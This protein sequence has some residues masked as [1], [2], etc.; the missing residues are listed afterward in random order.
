MI[1]KSPK[2]TDV[3]SQRSATLSQTEII[4]N[5]LQVLNTDDLNSIRLEDENGNGKAITFGVPIRF[6][7][8]DGKTQFIDTSMT[9]TGL[10]T[11]LFS[12]YEYRN[13]A[14]DTTFRFSKQAEKGV[15]IDEKFTYAVYNVENR[16]MPKGYVDQTF[17]GNGRM[18]YPEAFGENTYVE[19]INTNT[20]LKENIVLK[21]N[22][23]KNR[24]EF[25][26][27]SNNYL[28]IL[29][30]DKTVIKV[31][32]KDNPF[33]IKY[34]FAELY[35]YDSYQ[36]QEYDTI[37]NEPSQTP[38][39]VGSAAGVPKESDANDTGDVG[40]NENT[41]RHYTEDNYYELTQ[42]ADGKYKIT[43]VVSATFLNDPN[44][45]YPVIIDPSVS[46]VGSNS[47]A[48][49][50]FVWQNEPNNAGNGSLTYLRFGQI[51]GGNI[52]AYYRFSQ[53]PALP[54][55]VNITDATLKFTFR[56]GTTTGANGVCMIVSDHQWDESS[57]TWNNQP[58]GEWGYGSSH[59]NFQYYNFY[60][61]PFVEMWYYGGYPNYGV[62]FTYD[63]MIDDYNSVVS[64]EGD[65]AR[66]PK[67]TITY[68]TA[69]AV[70]M[71]STYTNHLG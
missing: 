33:D 15:Q 36:P 1:K 35:V 67:L 60:V 34:Q 6:V 63:V 7:D 5:K 24:F 38:I 56:S 46:S 31:V 65:A 69:P 45:I 4:T 17:E 12:G 70:S 20:G 13:A 9:K 49:D 41:F 10:F 51:S 50:T 32:D 23:G 62:N 44:T 25:I 21:E 43:S 26:F 57:L 3:Y 11:S 2:K 16:E 58:Y 28:P 64:T 59:N 37:E 47:T 8:N 19:Y 18:V 48:Q 42:L 53:L 22:V 40:V 29:S 61:K 66:A 27:E 54:A 39:F 55:S 68:S 52:H 71:N 30:E 14:F